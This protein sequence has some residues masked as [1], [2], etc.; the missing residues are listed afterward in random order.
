MITPTDL[1]VFEVDC[2][3]CHRRDW[4]TGVDEADAVRQLTAEG[5][6]AGLVCLSCQHDEGLTVA[7]QAGIPMVSVPDLEAG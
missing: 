1:R 7:Q 5:W 2:A 6:T 3:R 4:P